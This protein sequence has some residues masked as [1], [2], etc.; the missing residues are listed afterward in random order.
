MQKTTL[1]EESARMKRLTT[2]LTIIALTLAT[3]CGSG[4]GSGGSG[5]ISSNLVAGFS[6]DQPA[7]P[8]NTVAM[9]EGSKT[10]DLVT[11]DITVTDTSGIYGAAFDITFN[12]NNAIFEGWSPGNLLETGGHTPYYDVDLVAAGQLVIVATRQGP[13]AGVTASGTRTM[14]R[15]TF[16][17]THE[18]GHGLAFQSQALYDDQ[19]QP[20]PIAVSWAEGDLTGVSSS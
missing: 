18:G 12:A 8:A 10:G 7:P 19:T 13:V 14:V 1:R 15:L 5:P 11:V 3:A 16:R 20:Q 17:V 9:A 4:G 6:P 2:S